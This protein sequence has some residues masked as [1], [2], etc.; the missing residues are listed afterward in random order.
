MGIWIAQSL[1]KMNIDLLYKYNFYPNSCSEKIH[2]KEK[3]SYLLMPNNLI[4]LKHTAGSIWIF[5]FAKVVLE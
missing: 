1:A 3:D 5:D 4:R 2:C